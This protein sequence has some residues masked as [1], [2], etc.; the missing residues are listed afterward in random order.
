[1]DPEVQKIQTVIWITPSKFNNIFLL[2]ILD[3]S[4]KFHQNR[5]CQFLQLSCSQ[6]NKQIEGQKWP[7]VRYFGG[8][9]MTLNEELSTSQISACLQRT[10]ICTYIYQSHRMIN[11]FPC[12][13]V[14][15]KCENISKKAKKWSSVRYFGG[16]WMT[17]NEELQG[18]ISACLQRT[19]I[20][21]I[22][23]S[24]RMIWLSVYGELGQKV[25]KW[26]KSDL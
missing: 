5:I 8:Q 7:S 17:F 22:Y 21:I 18:Q 10:Y 24:H 23:T 2:A 15:V 12:N 16:Q 13:I 19:Y 14:R 11:D 4:W 1:M 20:C 26:P 6:T 25:K 9:W 3:I